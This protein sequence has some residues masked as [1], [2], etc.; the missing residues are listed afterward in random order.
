MYFEPTSELNALL[1]RNDAP[2][3]A[4]SIWE[5]RHDFNVAQELGA[6]L[7]S[8]N[9]GLSSQRKVQRATAL[10][11]LDRAMERNAT[12]FAYPEVFQLL[13]MR[14]LSDFVTCSVS[15]KTPSVTDAN[16]DLLPLGHPDCAAD[17]SQFS[18]EFVRE[19]QIEWKSSDPRVNE[20]YISL[21]ASAMRAPSGSLE[22]TFIVTKLEATKAEDVPRD[23][24][25]SIINDIQ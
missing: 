19:H 20:D 13:V 12:A 10:E 14:E 15:G 24:I 3:D 6:L 7:A 1:E 21:V 5:V 2:V 23:L 16:N 9:S 17:F 8:A 25:I 4:A 22:Q 18:E 11:V